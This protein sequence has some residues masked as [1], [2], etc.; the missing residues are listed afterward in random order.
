MTPTNQTTADA[1]YG[2]PPLHEQRV[3]TEEA[4]LAECASRHMPFAT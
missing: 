4:P 2:P 3:T 1:V